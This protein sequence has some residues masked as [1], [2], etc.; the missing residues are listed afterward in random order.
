MRAPLSETS[1][2]KAALKYSPAVSFRR[3]RS[4]DKFDERTNFL[5]PVEDDLTARNVFTREESPKRL[6]QT[7]ILIPD[8]DEETNEYNAS[9]SR[10]V[11]NPTVRSNG[12]LKTSVH[13]TRILPP[14]KPIFSASTF[15]SANREAMDEKESVFSGSF[16]AGN[17][18]AEEGLDLD[19]GDSALSPLKSTQSSQSTYYEEKYD[20]S[21]Y[22]TKSEK[23][24]PSIYDTQSTVY[25]DSLHES[26]VI[27]ERMKQSINR[28][29]FSDI[30]QDCQP[31]RNQQCTS[32]KQFA[33]RNG[34]LILDNAV[35]SKLLQ[36]L[37]F[38]GEDEF[39]YMRYSAI[40]CDPDFFVESGFNLR[41]NE[42][43]RSTELVVCITMYN[44][45]EGA[46]SRTMHAVMK[47]VAYLCKRKK[48]R[49]WGEDAWKKVVIVI[50]ADGR[51]KVHEGVLD[52]LS[53]M[54]VY[55]DGIAKSFV[56]S[57]PV[58]AHFFEYTTQL[59]IDEDLSFAGNDKGLVPVQ[60]CFCLKEK[61]VRKINS[62]RWLF[63]AICPS[64]EPNVC[65]L[66]DVGT[67]PDTDALYHL[68]K[69]FD[70]DSNVAGAAGEI[71]TIKGKW[72]KNLINPLVAS[73]NFEYKM[74]NILDKPVESTFGYIS[75]LP[76]AL[77]AYRYCALKNHE[78][79]TGPLQSY[80]KGEKLE[81]S[82]SNNIFTANM[83]LAEDR[84]LCWELVAKRG[85]KWVLKY[86]K[87]A[88]GATDVPERLPEF[89]SQR[90]RWLNGAFFA[91]LYSLLHFTQIWHTDHSTVRKFFLQIE[92]FY[93][94]IQLLFSLFS[95]G[96]FY[97]AFYYLSGSIISDSFIPH[98]GGFWMFQ[99][100]NYL[101]VCDLAAIFLISMGNRPQGAPK[102]FLTSLFILT[103]CGIYALVCG[104]FSM[105]YT[106]HQH[107]MGSAG[108][109]A[110]LQ[111]IISL[112]STYGLYAVMS[113]IYLDPWHILTSS[114]QYFILLP[115]YTCMLQIYAFCNT[116]DVSWGTKGENTPQSNLGTAVVRT[117]TSGKEIVEVEIIGD[118]KDIDNVYDE[119]LFNLRSR[120][121]VP[122][123]VRNFEPTPKI[124]DG[125]HYR[126]IRTR[127]VLFWLVANLVL[128]MTITQIYKPGD[129][130]TNKYL[131][132]IMWSVFCL[133]LFRAIG[134]CCYLAHQGLRWAVQ[135]RHKM[136]ISGD[137][138]R[139]PSLQGLKSKLGMSD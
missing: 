18:K 9:P 35:P 93:Q 36:F 66:L 52:V 102:L 122:E 86:V 67:Q 89:I 14:P 40:T 20:G 42:L 68:W 17:R 131:A 26:E 119:A 92:F 129:I 110:F 115:S 74:S 75:V 120:R 136:Q 7:P 5:R 104:F 101:C 44:E 87:A 41:A 107:E 134:S 96:N 78:D 106:I 28:N 30:P 1:P 108:E 109:S 6:R 59:S 111:I 54:G 11:R 124:S 132:F 47:N 83:Y 114:L 81:E 48:S 79:G 43:Q 98:K 23:I 10:F 84:I 49:V 76:G 62:H 128:V 137:G 3:S 16:V 88:K 60:I 13:S 50:V 133:A 64:I 125:D 51:D 77:S 38:T 130:K 45:S 39:Q 29:M 61:N 24:E 91:A 69:A 70:R 31:R 113:V 121:S 57:K 85:D 8:S 139:A 58:E 46:F 4:P 72:G 138:H 112:C 126:D 95:L 65:V 80:F 135:A 90:R 71:K 117:D 27:E 12:S 99:I 2:S 21:A 103:F 19:L 82:E 53:A 97:L 127:V 22:D 123:S 33:S 63:N 34:N 25:S 73:Q 56:N 94:F 15:A 105:I 32:A 118:Q 55:Q 37:P 100:V 116:H